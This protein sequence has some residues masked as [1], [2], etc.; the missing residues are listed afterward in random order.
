MLLAQPTNAGPT[1]GY[2]GPVSVQ[3]SITSQTPEVAVI[4][5]S[6]PQGK[7]VIFQPRA[8]NKEGA[9]PPPSFVNLS[10]MMSTPDGYRL[11]GYDVHH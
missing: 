7:M 5:P 4:S 11:D 1:K 6:D 10:C 2:D 8:L 3:Y 9:G